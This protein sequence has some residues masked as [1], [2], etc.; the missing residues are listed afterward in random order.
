MFA[1]GLCSHQLTEEA[2]LLMIRLGTDLEVEQIIIRNHF[3][4]FFEERG[5][6]SCLV[7]Y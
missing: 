2:S 5:M 7:L 6:Q 3:L 1:V 4:G